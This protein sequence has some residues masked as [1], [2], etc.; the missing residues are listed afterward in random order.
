MHERGGRP[1]S[2][3]QSAS[4]VARSRLASSRGS[5]VPP[6]SER[7]SGVVMFLRTALVPPVTS[8]DPANSAEASKMS[9]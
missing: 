8:P 6:A 7:I 9:W 2:R 3:A 5:P 4:Q 1:G